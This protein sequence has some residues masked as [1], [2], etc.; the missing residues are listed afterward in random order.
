VAAEAV[1]ACLEFAHESFNEPALP[2]RGKP[3]IDSVPLDLDPVKQVGLMAGKVGEPPMDSALKNRR[4]LATEKRQQIL[5]KF[6][7]HRSTD[8]A[9]QM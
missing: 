3:K 6:G 5:L 2:A 7:G 1:S 9:T 4:I 8:L